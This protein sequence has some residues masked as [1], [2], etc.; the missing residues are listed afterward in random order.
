M[1]KVSSHWLTRRGIPARVICTDMLDAKYSIIALIKKEGADCETPIFLTAEGKSHEDGTISGHDLVE[2]IEEAP[3][4]WID[5]V[6]DKKGSMPVSS[7]EIVD[8]K[9]NNGRIYYSLAAC[10]FEWDR[11]MADQ[12]IVAYRKSI[13]EE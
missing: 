12:D 3:D 5:W 4:A 6:S 2:L 8:V 13:L 9:L 7:D 11:D 10:Y 1:F